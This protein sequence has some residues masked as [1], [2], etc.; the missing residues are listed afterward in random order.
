MGLLEGM[1]DKLMGSLSG[2]EAGG[3][4][5]LLSSVL[6]K[7]DMGGLQGMVGRLEEAGFGRQVQSWL[8]NGHNLPISADQL[9]AAL[10]NEQVQ[11]VVRHFGLPIDDA[12]KLLAEHLPSAVDQASP[13][14]R[15]PAA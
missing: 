2:G 1:R 7:T 11:Q 14:G 3:P 4:A 13:T 12:M 8:G 15:L 10:G 9:R 5:A 6:A